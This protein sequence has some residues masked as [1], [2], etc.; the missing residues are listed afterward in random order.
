MQ[1]KTNEMKNFIFP[2]LCEIFS[3]KNIRSHCLQ[4]AYS[5]STH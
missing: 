3:A 5:P 4:G 1:A 2:I